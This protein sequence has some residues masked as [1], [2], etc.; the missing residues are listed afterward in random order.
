V[1]NCQR[2]D[3]QVNGKC[4]SVATL[5]ANA[6]CSNSSC[7]AGQTPIG[8]SNFCCTSSEVYTGANGA[9]VCCSQPLVNGQCQPPPPPS[10]CLVGYVPVGGS[11]CLASQMTSTGKCC[12]AGQTPSGANNSQC[13]PFIPVHLPPLTCCPTGQ[14]PVTGAKPC[15][16][17]ANVTSNGVCCPGPVDPNDRAQCRRL[18]PIGPTCARGYTRMPDGSCCNNR[19]VSADRTSC[20]IPRRP[21]APGEFRELSGACVPMPIPTCRP[22]E[23]RTREGRCVPAL[24]PPCPPGEIR[25]GGECVPERP[26]C[27]PG[28]VRR[29]GRC[30][31]SAPTTCPPGETLRRGACVPPRSA[32]CP[33]GQVRRRGRCIAPVPA[34]CPPG[35]M[36]REGRCAAPAGRAC[37]PGMVRTPRGICVHIGLP[38]RLPGGGGFGPPGGR[39]APPR[40][41][42]P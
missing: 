42:F 2:P 7:P 26:T 11:C 29:E 28:E 21:C 41:L 14:I 12:P 15:C 1:P 23:V 34:P 5:V 19:Y 25:R 22:G 38:P 39:I 4:C 40:R 20:N 31:R 3:I 27:P 30:V 24:P 37:P 18:I 33:P 36:R 9:Q 13:V 32:A 8:P 10:T 35:Q 17:T 6:A 16:P